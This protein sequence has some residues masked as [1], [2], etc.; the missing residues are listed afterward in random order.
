MPLWLL[1]GLWDFVL[2]CARSQQGSQHSRAM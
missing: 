1:R 2:L